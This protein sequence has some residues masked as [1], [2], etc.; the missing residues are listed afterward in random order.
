MAEDEIGV[1]DD[2]LDEEDTPGQE[3]E[4]LLSSEPLVHRPA[5]ERDHPV[6][7]RVHPVPV[8]ENVRPD[9]VKVVVHQPRE[10]HFLSNPHF[11][12]ADRASP[13]S[14][15]VPTEKVP[16][17]KVVQNE[18]LYTSTSRRSSSA[19][20]SSPEAASPSPDC[21]PVPKL[22]SLPPPS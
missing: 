12:P 9:G 7:E 8:E 13:P 3:S 20:R 4:A 6:E 1:A 11:R 21:C 2:L 22:G 14:E 16:L 17:K 15:G 18:E 10:S 19:P 5:E